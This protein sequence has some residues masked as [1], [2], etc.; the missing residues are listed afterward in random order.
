VT[1]FIRFVPIKILGFLHHN[2]HQQFIQKKEEKKKKKKNN[3]TKRPN[4][5]VRRPLLSYHYQLIH[6]SPSL[7]RALSFIY[8]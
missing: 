6:G 5:A 2:Q 8:M 3:G 1:A 7:P 4:F